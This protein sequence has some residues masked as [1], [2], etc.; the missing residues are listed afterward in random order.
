MHHHTDPFSLQ[1]TPARVAEVE[2]SVQEKVPPS[3]GQ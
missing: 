1:T 3:E 2:H